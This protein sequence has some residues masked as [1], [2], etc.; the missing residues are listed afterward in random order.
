[1]NFAR[2]NMTNTNFDTY[3]RHE[4]EYDH[5]RDGYHQLGPQYDHDRGHQQKAEPCCLLKDTQVLTPI[6]LRAAN[7]RVLAESF[8]DKAVRWA[9]D[10]AAEY[11]PQG[12]H[13]I[14]EMP[15]PRVKSTR[16]LPKV[17]RD[18]F[19]ECARQREAA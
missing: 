2:K 11:K 10:D 3:D 16:Q 15:S 14:E 1:M 4:S 12:P 18:A 19:A 9:F 13:S 17:M 8:M 6:G 7:K 5:W